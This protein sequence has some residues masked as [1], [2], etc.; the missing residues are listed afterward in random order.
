MR[1]FVGSSTSVLILLLAFASIAPRAS[2][3]QGCIAFYPAKVI[4]ASHASCGGGPMYGYASATVVACQV[5][6]AGAGT[7]LAE[8]SGY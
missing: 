2:A 8:H 5:P 1:R 7:C 3:Q 4:N 6:T